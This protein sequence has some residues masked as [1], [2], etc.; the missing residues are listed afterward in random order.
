MFPKP[1]SVLLPNTYEYETE[2]LVTANGFR[3]Y[4]ARWLFG[5]E[6]NLL[7]VQALGLGL[8]TFPTSS[9]SAQGR[10]RPRLPLLFG[11][12]KQALIIGLMPA[13]CEVVDIGL[14][15]DADRLFRAVRARLPGVAMVTA[16]HNENGW[17]GVKMGA[18]RPLTFGPDEIKP[19]EGDRARRRIQ[20]AAG[21]SYRV[22]REFSGALSRGAD[23]GPKLSRPLKVMAAC[24]NGT[25]GVF[26]PRS[27]APH[28]RRSDPLDMRS[29]LH[30]SNYN[31][32]PEDLHMLH[33]MG[34]G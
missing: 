20:A 12:I 32:N 5:K 26:A 14:A 28:R 22:R 11:S 1:K 30:L 15:H 18:Q 19:P 31:P 17:T 9:A 25:A 23:Q 27:A 8:G 13:G 33:A 29:R 10:H 3:E 16:S 34:E 2:P 4:D 7:G 24:G 6:I 21:G